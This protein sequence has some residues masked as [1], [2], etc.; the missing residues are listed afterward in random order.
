MGSIA[1]AIGGVVGDI[2]GSSAQASAGKRAGKIQAKAAQAGIEEQRR[3]FDA[4]IQLMS[5]YVAAGAPAL[6]QQ[7]AMAGLRGP[8]A[9]QAA[10]EAIAASPQLE[11]LARQGEEAIL[12]RASA[13]GGLR[14]GNVQAALAQFRPQLLQQLIEQRYSQL[15][16][17][18]DIGRTSAMAQGEAGMMTGTN[19]ANLLLGKGAA[20]AGGKIAAGQAQSMAF[21][22][23]MRIGAA[24]ASGGASEAGGGLL[25]KLGGLF[26]GGTAAA[27]GASGG[28]SAISN[29]FVGQT[30]GVNPA[31]TGKTASFFTG[32]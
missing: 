1:K 29:P 17:F 16:G 5:P 12:Q 2:T 24:I 11:A 21:N 10:I 25:G 8:E 27:P 6:E 23:L 22:D 7:M 18:T 26:G 32:I 31:L 13:T 20:M 28:F 19:V 4:L 14:G 15:G 3:Q 30:F 9:E